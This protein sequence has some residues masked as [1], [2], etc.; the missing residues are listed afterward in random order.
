VAVRRAQRD[1]EQV[2]CRVCGSESRLH[3]DDDTVQLEMTGTKGDAAALSPD[4]DHDLIGTM[5]ADIGRY[6]L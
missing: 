4:S 2:Y 3:K 1:G 6:V 5:V